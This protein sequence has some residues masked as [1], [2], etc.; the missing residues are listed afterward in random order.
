[1]ALRE[2]VVQ[3]VGSSEQG[4]VMWARVEGRVENALLKLSFKGA[5][6]FRPGVIWPMHGAVSKTRPYQLL[7]SIMAPALPVLQ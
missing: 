5:Y 1:M 7:Y 6:M 3:L 4:R 2:L